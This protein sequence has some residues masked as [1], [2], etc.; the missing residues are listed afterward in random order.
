MNQP[1][2]DRDQL[3]AAAATV[4]QNAYAPYS[5]FKVGAAV[6][7]RSGRIYTGCN[8]EN[9]SYG[10]TICAER[11]AIFKAVADGEDR[12][13]ALAV[14]LQGAGSPCGACRQ[15][16]HKFGPAIPIL[17][18]DPYGKLIG[19]T[20]LNKLLPDAFGP[21]FLETWCSSSLSRNLKSVIVSN[22]QVLFFWNAG[23]DTN[24]ID[25][26]QGA[27]LAA[28]NKSRGVSVA[29]AVALRMVLPPVNAKEHKNI[30]ESA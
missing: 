22:I 1:K 8:V 17:A 28:L 4:R 7:T 15:V 19:E 21:G 20:T 30:G 24:C 16:I 9:A 26:E 5:N 11:A 14:C 2:L 13:M 25:P 27:E 29:T 12:L 3:M 10:L 18:C 23:C 6:L